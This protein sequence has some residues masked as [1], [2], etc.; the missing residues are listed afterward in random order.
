MLNTDCTPK[1]ARGFIADY[2]QLP[3]SRPVAPA[4]LIPAIPGS[5]PDGEIFAA[6]NDYRRAIRY[7]DALPD[8]HLDAEY[9]AYVMFVESA[10]DRLRTI[11]ATTLQG[12]ALKMR[13]LWAAIGE[14]TEH[15]DV[16]IYDA[17]VT[18][19]AISDGRHRQLWEMIGDVERM[20]IAREA[21]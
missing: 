16:I 6:W 3:P 9:E 1:Q 21:V 19:E 15:Y 10:E 12:L 7:F 2:I 11:P 18:E 20:A 13:F 14:E 17:P 5:C 4:A 8:D